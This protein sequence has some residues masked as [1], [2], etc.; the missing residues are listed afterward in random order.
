MILS[1][2]SHLF[3][4][5]CLLFQKWFSFYKS[6][7]YK[8][9]RVLF[10]RQIQEDRLLLI[11]RMAKILETFTRNTRIESDPWVRKSQTPSDKVMC[12]SPMVFVSTMRN[13]NQ[14]NIEKK[15][16]T[17]LDTDLFASV[18]SWL[19]FQ[20]HPRFICKSGNILSQFE[21]LRHNQNHINHRCSE[22]RPCHL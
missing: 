9:L 1:T 11:E 19:G 20:S 10:F 13:L 8:E 4:N 5:P 22:L 18:Y 21:N 12:V 3:L 7:P 14:I 6:W 16:P 2:C 15:Y 17:L